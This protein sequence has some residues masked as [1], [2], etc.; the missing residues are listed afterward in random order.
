MSLRATR[1]PMVVRLFLTAFSVALALASVPAASAAPPLS[2]WP[3]EAVDAVAAELG[4][5][6]AQAG[7]R[8]A[9][10]D[11]AAV[12]AQDMAATL[13]DRAAGSWLDP[14]GALVVAVTDEAA[15]AQVRA[16]G[17][18]AKVVPHS[19]ARLD[20]AVAGLEAV[21]P[22]GVAWGADAPTNGLFVEVPAG[23]DASAFLAAARATGLPVTV[24]TVPSAVTP[25]AY[26]GGEALLLGSGGR[27]SAGFISQAPSGNQY[28]ITAG[29]CGR[30]GTS[31]RDES[32]VSIGAFAASSFPGNDYAAVRINSPASLAPQ[33]AV[34]TQGIIYGEGA[35]ESGIRDITGSTAAPVG[36]YVCRAGS[37]TG[38]RCG[39]VQAY[40]ATVNYSQGA[41]YGLIRT[42][43]CAEP[44]DS[45]GAL[46]AGSQAQG[47]T[48]GG[49]GN[50]SSGGTTYFQ[51]VNEAL[52]VYGLRLR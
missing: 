50:C 14:Q 30:A 29:H 45:G 37:T 32:G 52:S 43:V 12:L 33:G 25:Y 19:Q 22:V 28:I 27:C 38:Y 20:Q 6:P 9:A 34:A 48:S 3:A 18:T 51:P 11:R 49:S 41:V 24:K 46:I 26:Y 31:T 17:A 2:A 21:A 44:G 23:L 40:N 42:S 36:G 16:A 13:G 8:L 4:L 47:M 7:E 39:N 35:G 5:T 15:A 1:V 10:Q